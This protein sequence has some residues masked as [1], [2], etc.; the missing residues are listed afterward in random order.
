MKKMI[1]VVF[2]LTV[3][4][5]APCGVFAQ[6]QTSTVQTVKTTESTGTE[7]AGT[8]SEFGPDTIM[9]RTETNTTPMSYTYTKTTTYV[10]ET[11]TPVSVETVKSGQPVTVY[12]TQ[13]GDRMIANKV[14]IRK[15]TTTT[16]TK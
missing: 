6:Q 4:V 9:V 3:L 15:T 7:S 1:S 12:Y 16:E 2:A 5:I 13:E 11:G 14:V 10:D 8:I